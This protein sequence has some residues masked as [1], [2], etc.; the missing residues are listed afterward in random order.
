M[1]KI[2]IIGRLTKDVELRYSKSGVAVSTFTLAVDRRFKNAQGEKEVDF[3]QVKS[4][5]QLAELAANYLSKGKMAAVS[6]SLQISS[7]T[8]KEGIKKYSTDV[9]ADDIQFLSPKGEQQES[10]GNSF[11]RE[12]DLGSDIPF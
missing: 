5:K 2:I 4:F 1:N 9:I 12:V 7:Y 11:G 10:P 3:I 8:D 6:G